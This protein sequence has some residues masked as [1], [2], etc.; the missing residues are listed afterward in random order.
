MTGSF[1]TNWARR[2]KPSWTA[3]SGCSSRDSPTHGGYNHQAATAA[4]R[5]EA[6][7][8]N[9]ELHMV[10]FFP[11]LARKDGRPIGAANAMQQLDG[12]QYQRW[13]RHRTPQ[14]PVDDRAG[15]SWQP[16]PTDRGLARPGVR[17]MSG[18]VTLA[19]TGDQH[20][21]LRRHLFPGDG[22]EAAAILLCGRRDGDRE[23]L[24]VRDIYGIPYAECTV[25]TPIRV[26]WP[27]D[28]IVPRLEHAETEGLSFIKVHS[29]P[30]GFPTFSTVDDIGDERLLPMLWGWIDAD[31]SV[32]SAVMLPNGQM[33]GRVLRAG[34]SFEPI[35]CISVAG[36]DLHFFGTPAPARRIFRTSPRRIRRRSMKARSNACDVFG[37]P[38]SV[39]RAPEAQSSNGSSALASACS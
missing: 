24:A 8:P 7:Y 14:N 25:R 5:L 9:A 33:F 31:V 21:F 15:Q 2:G 12:K 35:E 23:R 16:H 18:G 32:G 3:P 37:S 26:S 36:D 19:L 1:S 39:R 28:Y 17:K 20:E 29:H 38:S 27:P 34:A 10:Y 13:S 30:T 6:G 11:A 4:V 22:N